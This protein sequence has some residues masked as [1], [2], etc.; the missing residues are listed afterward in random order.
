VENKKIRATASK[1]Q[2][3]DLQDSSLRY[4]L[5]LFNLAGL[6]TRGSCSRLRLPALEWFVQW[7]FAAGISTYSAGPKRYGFSP[8]SLFSIR[9]QSDDTR[10]RPN[11]YARKTML[12]QVGAYPAL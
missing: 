5:F 1:S 4:C 8:Y 11:S 3:A 12:D 6:L 10:S 9:L 2:D 7:H